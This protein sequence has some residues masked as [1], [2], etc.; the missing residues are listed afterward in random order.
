MIL[1]LSQELHFTIPVLT[2]LGTKT[3][4]VFVFHNMLINVL[5]R[6]ISPLKTWVE[7]QPLALHCLILCLTVI[8]ITSTPVFGWPLNQIMRVPARFR[9]DE[10]MTA[11]G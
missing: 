11:Q 6:T 4:S 10:V 1:L 3:L 7:S 9:E 8:L 2:K 5:L